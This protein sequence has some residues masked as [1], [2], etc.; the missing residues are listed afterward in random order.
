MLGGASAVRTIALIAPFNRH[1]LGSTNG[2]V[3]VPV[4]PIHKSASLSDN[5]R[6]RHREHRPQRAHLAETAELG[7]G[8][9]CFIVGISR[10]VDR[11]ACGAVIKAK[12][13]ACAVV[14]EVRRDGFEPLPGD[15]RFIRLGYQ[16][17]E[18]PQQQ[19]SCVFF[20][21]TFGKPRIV[22]TQI[23]GPVE[24]IAGEN[25]YHECSGIRD[26]ASDKGTTENLI[27]EL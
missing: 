9:H 16:C 19:K 1:C 22:A 3:A 14:G 10:D 2:T 25:I 11:K 7:E 18:F 20:F 27:C 6:L 17:M 12:E 21:Q 5:A 15:R 8:R 24:W 26:Q 13:H 23:C 4:V